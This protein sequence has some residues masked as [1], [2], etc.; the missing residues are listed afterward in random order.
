[1]GAA[2]TVPIAINENTKVVDEHAQPKIAESKETNE[3]KKV[4]FLI[5]LNCYVHVINL[6]IL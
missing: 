4:W 1:M 5:R 2:S 6:L 3:G